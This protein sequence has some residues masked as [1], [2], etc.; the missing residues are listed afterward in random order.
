[1]ERYAKLPLQVVNDTLSY[2]VEKPYKEV[3]GLIQTINQ[4]FTVIVDPDKDTDKVDNSK[5]AKK[6]DTK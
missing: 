3:A 2:L 5:A 1:M 4:N 6:K